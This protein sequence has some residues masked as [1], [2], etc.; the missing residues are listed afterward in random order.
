[1]SITNMEK[2]KNY[3]EQFG[4]L[5]RA[6]ANEFYLEAIFIE[7]AII[8]DRTTSI[9]RHAGVYNPEKHNKLVP[10]IRRIREIIKV[11]NRKELLKKYITDELLDDI[12]SWKDERN[13]LIHDLLNQQV[14]KDQ[15][16]TCAERGSEICK[17]LRNKAGSYAR[18]LEK[19][20]NA[21][22]E[23]LS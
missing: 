19:A 21:V 5:K 3:K 10:K 18:S 23:K 13:A 14:S 7:Y 4:R 9:L 20:N 17:T 1:M 8:E 16:K 6:L 11:K 2:Y 22:K 15:L 12:N